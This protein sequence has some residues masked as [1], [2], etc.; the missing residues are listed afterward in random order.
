MVH[1]S[2]F[3]TSKERRMSSHFKYRILFVDDEVAIRKTAQAILEDQGYEVVT[4][5]HGLDA[6][7]S[8]CG[9]LPEL[10]ITDLRMPKMSGFELLAVVRRRFPQIPTVAIS[11]EYLTTSVHEALL[12]DAFLQKGHYSVDEYLNKIKD[13][14]GKAPARPFPGT[15]MIQ[16]IWVPIHGAGEILVTCPQCLRSFEINARDLG[17]GVHQAACS[18][19]RATFDFNVDEINLET[20]RRSKPQVRSKTFKA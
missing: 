3:W 10:L 7:Q 19:C 17:V 12:A 9:P 15:Q 14:L 4:A 13:L 16:A 8:L 11:G 2:D 6:L 1:R 5:E 18:F 20:V